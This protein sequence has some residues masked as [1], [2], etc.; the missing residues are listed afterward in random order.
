MSAPSLSAFPVSGCAK[1]VSCIAGAG[2][3][4]A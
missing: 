4:A 3:S 2:V 1:Y